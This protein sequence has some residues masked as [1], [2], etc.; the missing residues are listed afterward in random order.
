MTSATFSRTA[1]RRRVRTAAAAAAL[2][3]ALTL[4][5]CSGDGGSDD[6]ASGGPSPS[7]SASASG[8][9]SGSADTGGAT[10]GSEGGT[11]ASDELEGSWLATTDGK[12]VA[13]VIT[14]AKAGLFATDGA[15]CSGTAGEESGA[16]TIR[17]KCSD[18]SKKRAEGTVDSVGGSTLE[19]TW[20]GG[21]G[22]ETYTRS[23]GGQLPSE[24][25]TASLGS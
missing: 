19:V 1:A 16:E 4:T 10:G 12:A 9:A 13:L 25:P 24:L 11:A 20:E 5:A 15:V 8:S 23:E 22:T 14:G 7:A 18:G 6:E 21:L 17:L 2:A 3:G